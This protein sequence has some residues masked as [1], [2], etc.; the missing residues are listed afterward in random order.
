MLEFDNQCVAE[1]VE[2]FPLN[3]SVIFQFGLSENILSALHFVHQCFRAHAH[4]ELRT[5]KYLF[6]LHTANS[7]AH[8]Y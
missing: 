6:L 8:F 7:C 1:R 4:Y 5:S 2:C 3:Y